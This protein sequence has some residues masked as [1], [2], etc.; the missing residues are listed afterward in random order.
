MD[1]KK[2]VGD[3]VAIAWA[4]WISDVAFEESTGVTAFTVSQFHGLTT[5]F[6]GGRMLII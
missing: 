3:Y 1:G 5:A 2:G 6:F 4:P